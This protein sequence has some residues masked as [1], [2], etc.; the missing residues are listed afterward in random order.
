VIVLTAWLVGF[1]FTVGAM[2]DDARFYDYLVAGFAWPV[3]IGHI[4]RWK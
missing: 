4:W 3:I 2:E 1:G